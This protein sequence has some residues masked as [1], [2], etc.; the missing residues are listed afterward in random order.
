MY[1]KY[2]YYV[3]CGCFIMCEELEIQKTKK[4]NIVNLGVFYFIIIDFLNYYYFK[5]VLF[6]YCL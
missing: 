3:I 6:S 1:Y 4:N 2:G 5:R